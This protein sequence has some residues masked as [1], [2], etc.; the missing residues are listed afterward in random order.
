MENKT[1]S[2]STTMYVV[3]LSTFAGFW[4][5]I[6]ILNLVQTI[7]DIKNNILNIGMWILALSFESFELLKNKEK[8]EPD[9]S[10]NTNWTNIRELV[11]TSIFLALFWI[12][13]T[14]NMFIPSL[15]IGASISVKF[16]PLFASTIFL[17]FRYAFMLGIIA[18]VSSLMFAPTV[19]AFG[20]WT[21]EYF[22]VL[23]V[24]SLGALFKVNSTSKISTINTTILIATI[25]WMLSFI[26]RVMASSIYW[27]QYAW[28]G[29]NVVLFAIIFNI[30][31][32]LIDYTVTL[33][34]IP[35]FLKLNQHI[36]FN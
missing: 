13:S 35:V 8:F 24:P 15:P 34:I 12:F 17:R 10:H 2:A 3:F 19:I 4:I 5:M 32:L 11:L 20:Q 33:M 36:K 29:Y 26:F 16:I 27:F 25:P 23:L 22:L 21:L 28:E 1:G 7:L 6:M 14:V 9:F 30:P 31:N 18:G